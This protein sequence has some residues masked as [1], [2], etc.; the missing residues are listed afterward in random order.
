MMWD[1]MC[2][3]KHLP[4]RMYLAVKKRTTESGQSL[5]FDQY[6]VQFATAT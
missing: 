4:T 1:E 6:K 3:I 2:R 5:K